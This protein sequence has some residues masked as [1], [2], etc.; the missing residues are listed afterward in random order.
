MVEGLGATRIG[1]VE[2]SPFIGEFF[3]S[4]LL[5]KFIPQPR[6]YSSRRLV[7]LESVIV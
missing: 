4:A 7:S 3:E 6:R 1:S 2:S 5:Q